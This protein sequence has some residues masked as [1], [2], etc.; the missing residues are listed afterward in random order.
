[1]QSVKKDE[2]LE[3]LEKIAYECIT[4]TTDVIDQ[5]GPDQF[6]S[7]SNAEAF[8]AAGYLKQEADELFRFGSPG[9]T[10]YF[11]ARTCIKQRF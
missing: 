6:A 4:N 11:A 8:L 7:L 1:M 9:M 2:A 10:E 5:S 3:I